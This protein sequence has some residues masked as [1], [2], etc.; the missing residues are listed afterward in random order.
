MDA[1]KYT[2]IKALIDGEIY[3]EKE[4]KILN[5]LEE[6]WANEIKSIII[7]VEENNVWFLSFV[8]HNCHEILFSF[9]MSKKIYVQKKKKRKRSW[10]FVTSYGYHRF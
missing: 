1:Y 3:R 6:K 8:I 9:K 2:Q 10:F 5:A 4:R 7:E